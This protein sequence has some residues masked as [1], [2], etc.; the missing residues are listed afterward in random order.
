MKNI[1]DN[2]VISIYNYFKKELKNIYDNKELSSMFFLICNELLNE[3]KSYIL[4]NWNR[5]LTESEILYFLNVIKRLK[6]NEPIQYILGK[7][8]FYGLD[9]FVNK[10][11]LIPRPETE[12]LVELI[13][14]TYKSNNNSLL[15]IDIGTGSGCIAISLVKNIKRLNMIATDISADALNLAKKNSIK[16]NIKN[17]TFV[18][19]DILNKNFH[20]E[21]NYSYD[22][23]VSNPP[24][25]TLDEK[26]NL[27][28]NVIDYEPHIALFAG[29]DPLIFYKS[30]IEFAVK[31]LKREGK[32]FFEL[33]ESKAN[34]LLKLFST[35]VFSNVEILKDINNKNRFLIANKK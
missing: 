26:Y 1:P 11:V 20:K 7:A 2:K 8:Y 24:Y 23:I 3:T 34:E 28:K 9:F 27:E 18:K 10:N 21:L 4:N 35:T 16:Y 30:I 6:K 13:I 14:H 22:F 17:I 15:G 19:N 29:N 31:Y 32:L 5:K 33:N 12:E 25:V